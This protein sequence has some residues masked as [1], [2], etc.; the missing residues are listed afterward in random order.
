M[1]TIL[2]VCASPAARSGTRAALEQF[3]VPRLVRHGHRVTW[4]S[5]R[6]LPA[7][8]LM[9]AD[10]AEPAIRRAAAELAAAE[11]VV[12]GTP[13]YKASFSGLLKVFLDVMPRDALSG[14]SVLPVATGSS[15]LHG[16]A[17]DYA[18]QPVLNSMGARHVVPGCYVTALNLKEGGTGPTALE[19]GA[20]RL[21]GSLGPAVPVRAA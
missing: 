6:D 15:P 12:I 14:K 20:D 18:L 8:P 10:A 5:V 3:V 11:G 17:L 13:V 4:L 1:A 7:G 19:H 21:L 16:L 2:T 9:E